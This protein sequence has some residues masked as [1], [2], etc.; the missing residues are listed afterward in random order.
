MIK[1][2]IGQQGRRNVLISGGVEIGHLGLLLNLNVQ[3]HNIFH[4]KSGGML[5][6]L[7][8]FSQSLNSHS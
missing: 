8:L 1:H 5:R 3:K 7:N 4:K 2:L 6:I